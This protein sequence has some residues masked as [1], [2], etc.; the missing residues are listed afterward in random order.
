MASWQ[1]VKA[2]EEKIVALAA[3][4]ASTMQLGILENN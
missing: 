4:N 2:L 1:D 3:K